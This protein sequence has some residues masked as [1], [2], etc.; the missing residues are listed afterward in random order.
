MFSG[1]VFGHLVYCRATCVLCEHVPR[2]TSAV[3]P[4]ATRRKDST[5]A[6]MMDGMMD[7]GMMDGSN[8]SFSVCLD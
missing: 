1:S 7:A 8:A 5:S 2:Y 3:A 6:G 4:V